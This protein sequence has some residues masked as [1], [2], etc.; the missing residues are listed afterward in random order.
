M[1]V[2]TGVQYKVAYAR[3]YYCGYGYALMDIGAGV[4]LVGLEVL[5]SSRAQSVARLFAV[6]VPYAYYSSLEAGLSQL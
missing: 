5:M 1:S 4:F 2:Y 3:D 6:G